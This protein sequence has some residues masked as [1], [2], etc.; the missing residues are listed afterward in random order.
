LT[1]ID[2]AFLRNPLHPD[3]YWHDRG[4]VLF[5]HGDYQG[6][7]NSLRRYQA[8]SDANYIYQAACLAALGETSEA[9]STLDQLRK[10]NNDVNLDWIRMAYP[11]RC[12]KDVESTTSLAELLS[13]AGLR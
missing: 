13:I 9:V 4:V 11:Y 6:A 2:L 1:Y 5:A 8:N 7:L 10:F 3:W 12:Y